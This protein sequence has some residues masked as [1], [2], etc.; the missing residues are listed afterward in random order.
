MTGP[1]TEPISLS[2]I[3]SIIPQA[4]KAPRTLLARRGSFFAPL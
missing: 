4:T 3:D 2:V 1:P